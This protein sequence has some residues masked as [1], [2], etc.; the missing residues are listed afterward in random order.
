M[1]PKFKFWLEKRIAGEF[2][3]GAPQ[4]LRCSVSLRYALWTSALVVGRG[5]LPCSF[6]PWVLHP[7]FGVGLVVRGIL[8]PLVAHDPTG[9]V[10]SP[11]DGGGRGALGVG[12]RLQP[13]CLGPW[14][15]ETDVK[16]RSGLRG[17]GQLGAW[18]L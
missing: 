2:H 13:W 14:G 4:W 12:Q 1:Y 9:R 16:S 15:W 11:T 7:R 3:Q 6:H 8:Q 17:G 10:A 5:A 18:V